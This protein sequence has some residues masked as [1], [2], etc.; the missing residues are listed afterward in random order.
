MKIL[1]NKK[2]FYIELYPSSIEEQKAMLKITP[3]IDDRALWK[4]VG[5]Q[6]AMLKHFSAA[7]KIIP[8]RQDLEPI[9]YFPPTKEAEEAVMFIVAAVGSCTTMTLKQTS[10]GKYFWRS[11]SLKK[12]FRPEKGQ[13]R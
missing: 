12:S 1:H 7:F 9:N 2:R 5:M 11:T 13:V 3:N 4:L 6:N 8:L 10:E